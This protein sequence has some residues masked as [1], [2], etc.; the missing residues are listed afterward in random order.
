MSEELDKIEDF[1]TILLFATAEKYYEETKKVSKTIQSSLITYP[2][3]HMPVDCPWAGVDSERI[4]TMDP[5]LL[6]DDPLKVVGPKEELAIYDTGGAQWFG[7]RLYSGNRK[8]YTTAAPPRAI[9]VEQHQ[10]N[11]RPDGREFYFSQ[12]SAWDPVNRRIWP[13]VPAHCARQKLRGSNKKQNQQALRMLVLMA[14][15]VE[16]SKPF[17]CVEV[18][19]STA[20]KTY[21]TEESVKKLAELRKAPLTQSGRKKAILH[22]VAEHVRKL[23]TGNQTTV[24]QHMR[25]IESF[26]VDGLDV[27]IF[28]PAKQPCK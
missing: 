27:S 28:N 16:D 12:M 7:Q 19:E 21:A 9:W 6:L 24:S 13:I 3:K 10:R 2:L 8:G 1:L 14:S 25:G 26:S 17:W 20:V 18:R 4:Y 5:D 22:W 23:P 15:F 11:I